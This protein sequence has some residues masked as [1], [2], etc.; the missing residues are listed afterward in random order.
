MKYLFFTIGILLVPTGVHAATLF[1]SPSTGHYEVGQTFTVTVRVNTQGIAINAAE[2]TLSFDQGMLNVV[3]LSTAGS[4]F[5]LNIQEPS[6]SNT[7]GTIRW[8][9]IILNPGYTGTAGMLLKVTF[10]GIKIGAG[11][12]GFTSGTVLANDGHA[13]NVLTNMLGEAYTLVQGTIPQTL[14]P[15]HTP[16]II[17]GVV[18]ITSDSMR[19]STSTHALTPTHPSALGHSMSQ[20]L[21]VIGGF[22]VGLLS[23]T[24]FLWR[25]WAHDLSHEGAGLLQKQDEAIVEKVRQMANDV[26]RQLGMLNREQSHLQEKLK[27]YRAAEKAFTDTHKQLVKKK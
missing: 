6:Y 1:L 7:D 9:G 13:S 15:T 22:M 3:G 27:K 19:A 12:I 24:L 5:N 2:G 8:S 4:I 10:K 25:K 16:S 21:P 17:I 11:H 20:V 26:E 18:D 23:A 14:V